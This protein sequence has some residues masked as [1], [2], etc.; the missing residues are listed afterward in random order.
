MVDSMHMP[1]LALLDDE[2]WQQAPSQGSQGRHTG[3]NS[4]L[5]NSRGRRPL[6]LEELS[7]Q[8][9][10]AH[11]GNL[12][13]GNLFVAHD[14]ALVRLSPLAGRAHPHADHPWLEAMDDARLHRVFRLQVCFPSFTSPCVFVCVCARARVCI[15]CMNVHGYV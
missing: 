4:A 9:L 2:P 14:G 12:F 11:D 1:S 10:V 3:A 7:L 13:D 6:G 5:Q 15:V 8:G